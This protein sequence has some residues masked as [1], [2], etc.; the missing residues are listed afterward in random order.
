MFKQESPLSPAKKQ[1]TLTNI[2]LFLVD[3][4][5]YDTLLGQMTL[6]QTWI[7]YQL[8]LRTAAVRMLHLG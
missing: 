1:V 7:F 2:W 6:Q 3:G 5:D 4:N 8:C